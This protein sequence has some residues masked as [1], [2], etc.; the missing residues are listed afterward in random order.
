MAGEFWRFGA[1][2]AFDFLIIAD[3]SGSSYFDGNFLL[4]PTESS[5]ERVEVGPASAEVPAGA[6]PKHNRRASS[7]LSSGP[8]PESEVGEDM[9]APTLLEDVGLQSLL[10]CIN[11]PL[12]SKTKRSYNEL[13]SVASLTPLIR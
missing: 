12:L 4:T 1:N 8:M 2:S 11:V 7:S 3:P 9:L 10:P 5:P 13:L 6:A